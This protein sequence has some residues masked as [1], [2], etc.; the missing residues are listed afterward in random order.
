MKPGSHTKP[1]AD[2]VHEGLAFAGAEQ[3]RAQAPQFE[4]SLARLTQDPLQLVVPAVQ[5]R[6]QALPEQ[7]CDELHTVVQVP[8]CWRSEARLTQRPPHGV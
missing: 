2:I 5:L 1:H 8:Q 3:V 7:L 4:L 6:R